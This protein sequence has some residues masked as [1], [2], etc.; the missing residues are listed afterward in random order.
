MQI[1]PTNPL[2]AL[3]GDDVSFGIFAI[4]HKN[5]AKKWYNRGGFAAFSLAEPSAAQDLSGNEI[6]MADNSLQ[7]TAKTASRAVWLPTARW[8]SASYECV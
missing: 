8:L 3:S 1:S 4:S 6:S 2:R 5:S 7:K